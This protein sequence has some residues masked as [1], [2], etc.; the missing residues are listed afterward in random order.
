MLLRQPVLALVGREE[1]VCT[2]GS[3]GGG[4]VD[5]KVGKGDQKEGA[6][7]KGRKET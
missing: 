5:D 2:S 6:K 1:V 7:E 4:A 3:G